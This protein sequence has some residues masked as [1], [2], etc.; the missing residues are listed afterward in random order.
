M[1]YQRSKALFISFILGIFYFLLILYFYV[2]AF[3][4][5][6]SEELGSGFAIIFLTPHLILIGLAVIFN[7]KGFYLRKSKYSIRGVILYAVGGFLSFYLLYILPII[8][9]SYIGYSKQ[10][11]LSL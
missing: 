5:T 6:A 8:I 3:T 10:K 2:E 9:L 4:G 7:W 11:K 1:F